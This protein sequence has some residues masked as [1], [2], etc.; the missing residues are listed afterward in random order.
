VHSETVAGC[1]HKYGGPQVVHKHSRARL[2]RSGDKKMSFYIH[3]F[4]HN[5]AACF[6]LI[7]STS[8]TVCFLITDG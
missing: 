1:T 7:R 8:D 5:C 4:S 3:Y 6:A 2:K